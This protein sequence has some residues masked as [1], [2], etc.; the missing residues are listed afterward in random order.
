MEPQEQ[1]DG[2]A[3]AD[4]VVA[5]GLVVAELLAA[6]DEPDVSGMHEG[7]RLEQNALLG[8]SDRVAVL[9][10]VDGDGLA[11]QGLH[12]DLHAATEWGT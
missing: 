2:V 11:H 12:D 6:E 3:R 7:V 10:V 5:D 8:G 4:V 1:E 9:D